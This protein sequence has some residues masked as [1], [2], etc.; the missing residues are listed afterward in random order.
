MTGHR[1]GVPSGSTDG[2]S[3]LLARCVA[4][5]RLPPGRAV[6]TTPTARSLLRAPRTAYTR[7]GRVRTFAACLPSHG[8][9]CELFIPLARRAAFTRQNF[10][11]SFLFYIAFNIS[12]ACCLPS[13]SWCVVASAATAGATGGATS[14]WR[15]EEQRFTP[16]FCVLMAA[17]HGSPIS[18]RVAILCGAAPRDSPA[19]TNM[20]RRRRTTGGTAGERKTWAEQSSCGEEKKDLRNSELHSWSSFPNHFCP[21]TS[22]SITFKRH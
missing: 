20:V 19:A 18:S 11:P 5:C 1:P 15:T 22:A 14:Q 10:T 8:A 7:A 2:N 16:P 21:W 6:P 12:H 3:H 17:S 9:T 13:S 4:R